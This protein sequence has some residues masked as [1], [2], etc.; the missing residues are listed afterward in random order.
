MKG[1][2]E[3]KW[4]APTTVAANFALVNGAPH[5][6]LANFGGL[7]PGKVVVPAPVNI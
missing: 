2:E 6:Y 4:N 7:V 1:D 5:V 3:I